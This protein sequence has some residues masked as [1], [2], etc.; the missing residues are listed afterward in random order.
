MPFFPRFAL[1]RRRPEAGSQQPKSG[2]WRQLHPQ[3]ARNSLIL[4]KIKAV[5]DRFVG[6][7]C[8]PL[9]VG[10]RRRDSARSGR[11]WP[12]GASSSR[13]SRCRMPSPRACSGA[14]KAAREAAA[15][16]ERRPAGKSGLGTRGGNR[17][18][19]ADFRYFLRQTEVNISLFIGISGFAKPEMHH[20]TRVYDAKWS[21]TPPPHRATQGVAHGGVGSARCT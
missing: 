9:R 20:Q 13:A 2:N 14:R 21:P 5:S 3:N 17:L 7:A 12:E 15:P 4:A 11:C 18:W 8:L 6:A 10:A 16:S 1:F 19:R